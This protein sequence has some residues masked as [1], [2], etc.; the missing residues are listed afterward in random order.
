MTWSFTFGCRSTYLIYL[1]MFK[2][3][4]SQVERV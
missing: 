1:D 2:D 4:A 3:F